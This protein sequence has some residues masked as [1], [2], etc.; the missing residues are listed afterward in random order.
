MSLQNKNITKQNIANE[1]SEPHQSPL[2]ELYFIN[3]KAA[4]TEDEALF[5]VSL[6]KI[7]KQASKQTKNPLPKKLQSIMDFHAHPTFRDVKI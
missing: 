2:L 5:Y 7:Q 3:S 4:L 6:R 1:V